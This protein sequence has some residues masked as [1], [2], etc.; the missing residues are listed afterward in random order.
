MTQSASPHHQPSPEASR[1]PSNGSGVPEVGPRGGFTTLGVAFLAGVVLGLLDLVAQHVLPYPWANLAN[2]PAVWALAAFVL[3]GRVARGR[4]LPAAAGVVLLVVA[5][6][7]YEAAAVVGLHDSTSLLLTEP[8]T[9]LWLLFGVLAGALF[10]SAGS[11]SR[12]SNGPLRVLGVALPVATFMTEAATQLLRVGDRNY[13][14]A[15]VL[16]TVAITLSLA[17]LVLVFAWR[18]GAERSC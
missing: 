8:S 5:V 6:E 3:G 4:W 15:S 1:M 11:W 7:A 2:S 10:G 17:V 12:R 9:V 14:Q 18:G 13:D 16:E